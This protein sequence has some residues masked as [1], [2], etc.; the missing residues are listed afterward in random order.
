LKSI[1]RKVDEEIIPGVSMGGVIIDSKIEDVLEALKGAHYILTR[2]GVAVV[3]EGLLYIGFEVD[4]RVCSIMSGPLFKGKFEGKLWPRMTVKDVLNNTHSQV[5]VGG[6]VVVDEIDGVG[7]PLPVGFDDFEQLT[8]HLPLDHIFE[9]IS[10]FR[11][12]S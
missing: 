9:G 3:D 10:V 2:D 6:C 5:A 7:L 12:F 1:A 8:D 4:G 11:K